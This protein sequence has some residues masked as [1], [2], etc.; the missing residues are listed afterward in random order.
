MLWQK[1]FDAIAIPR[2]TPIIQAPVMVSKPTSPIVKFTSRSVSIQTAAIETTPSQVVSQII[3]PPS[4]SEQLHVK[5]ELVEKQRTITELKSKI[6]DLEMTISLFRTQIGD[7][8]SQISFYAK[9][10]LELQNKKPVEV[11]SGGAGGDNISIG[12]VDSAGNNEELLTLKV[13]KTVIKI[14]IVKEWFSTF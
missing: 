3:K 14:N 8:Q 7:K 13:R 1:N 12:M 10:I 11:H 4:V 5:E 6:S 2:E 9:H